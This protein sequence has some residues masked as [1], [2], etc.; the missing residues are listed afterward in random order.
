[1]FPVAV[2]S[3]QCNEYRDACTEAHNDQPE[4]TSAA[5]VW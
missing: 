3:A 2:K 5:Q 4:R 1:M